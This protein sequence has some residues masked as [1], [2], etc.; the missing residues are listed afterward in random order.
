MDL[1]VLFFAS[2]RDLTGTGSLQLQV[3]PGTTVG[4][5][6]ASVRARGEGFAALPERPAVAVNHAVVPHDHALAA[7]DEVAFLPPV[8]GG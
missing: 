5:L 3:E 7:G 8:A 4:E 6:V 2:Y 1:D